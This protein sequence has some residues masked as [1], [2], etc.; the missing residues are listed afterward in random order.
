MLLI[1]FSHEDAF[2]NYGVFNSSSNKMLVIFLRESLEGKGYATADNCGANQREPH[3][4]AATHDYYDSRAAHR[5][6]TLAE[7]GTPPR[8]HEGS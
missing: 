1:C 2:V 4:P 7:A 3:Q 5:N 6:V 8:L